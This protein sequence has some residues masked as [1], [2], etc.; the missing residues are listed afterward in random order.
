MNISKY[1]LR[2]RLYKRSY[3]L[4]SKFQALFSA[5]FAGFWL[6]IIDRK[7]W[8]LAD[9][10]FYDNDGMYQ[11]ES[12][13][14]SGLWDWEA[15][16]ISKYFQASTQIL[17]AGAGGGREIYA[18]SKQGY[19]VD[20]FECN[21]QF[22]AYANRFL[23]QENI[24]SEVMLSPR[25]TCPSLNR[26]YNGAIIGWGAYT[27]IQGK[28]H[29]INFLQQ[30]RSHLA[31][32][33]PILLSFY[34]RTKDSNSFKLIFFIAHMIAKL[35]NFEAIELGDSLYPHLIFVHYFNEVEIKS[36]LEQAGFE[37]LFYSD[38]DYG[39]AVGINK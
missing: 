25:D 7:S 17:L 33:S 16:I 6:G 20:G 34:P 28:Q 22:A 36:E 21:P 31:P 2:L 30:I 13:N 19:Q 11:D 8:Q 10:I 9:G 5:I 3:L 18:L 12:Y 23:K 26:I 14:R 4:F 39:K 32:E 38:Q 35:R 24:D 15:E 37:L 1:P 29:R 27:N